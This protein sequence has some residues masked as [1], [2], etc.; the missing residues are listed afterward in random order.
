[1][2]F[3]KTSSECSYDLYI[4]FYDSRCL[5]RQRPKSSKMAQK[6]RFLDFNGKFKLPQKSFQTSQ[7]HSK[8][9]IGKLRTHTFYL[10]K[11]F[12]FSCIF[13][14][15]TVFLRFYTQ[16]EFPESPI[17]CKIWGIPF[18]LQKCM[19]NQNFLINRKYGS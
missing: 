16:L 12:D 9:V 2:H 10:L 17:G 4:K 18:G 7:R 15:R 8:D 3:P 13:V 5:G 11:N 14:T 6:C 1:M 19:K